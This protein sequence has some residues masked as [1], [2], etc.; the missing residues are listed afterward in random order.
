MDR[1]GGSNTLLTSSSAN[2]PAIG[3]AAITMKMCRNGTSVTVFANG[4]Q[5]TTL[6]AT[7]TTTAVGKAGI[8]AAGQATSTTGIHL[9]NFSAKVVAPSDFVTDTFTEASD[10]TLASHTGEVG[11]TWTL[12][13][14]YSGAALDNGSLKR[15]YLNTSAAAAYYASGVPPGANYC[16]QADFNRVTQISNNISI[17]IG[18]DTA[19]DAGLL[20]RGNDT[21]STFVWELM[22]RAGG[23][24]TL[25][26]YSS[27]N[28]PAIGGAAITMKMCRNGTSVTVFANGVQDTTLN[29]TTTTTAVGKAGI[30]ASGQATSTTGIHLDNFRAQ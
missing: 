4:V 30:R 9:D 14:S 5:D 11:A 3:G 16:V 27:A 17:I 13:P 1:A 8:R 26:T 24:N 23:S 28:Q 21:G 15:I 20:L 7:T 29:A 2:Q 22:D 6:N 19:A 25:L 10:T 12:H 18:M